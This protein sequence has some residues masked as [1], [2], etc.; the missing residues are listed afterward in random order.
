M[1]FGLGLFREEGSEHLSLVDVQQY[2]VGFEEEGSTLKS[3]GSSHGSGG[4]RV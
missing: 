3:P 1:L 4:C 2:P